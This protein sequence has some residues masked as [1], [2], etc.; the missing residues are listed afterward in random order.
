MVKTFFQ[1]MAQMASGGISLA[2]SVRQQ[3][4]GEIRAGI[5]DMVTRLDLVPAEDLHRV[6]ALLQDAIIRQEQLEKRIE[7]L[8]TSTKPSNK[9]SGKKSK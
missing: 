9:T 3:I 5:D 1:D 2:S 6:E 8:E 4:K 7:A